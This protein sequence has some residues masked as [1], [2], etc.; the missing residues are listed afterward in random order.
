MGAVE[1][2]L[3]EPLAGQALLTDALA[4][5]AGSSMAEDS[6]TAARAELRR[7]RIEFSLASN[8]RERRRALWP[9]L[10]LVESSVYLLYL[11]RGSPARARAGGT[12]SKMVSSLMK[13]H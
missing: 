12:G 10:C 8:Y 9:P 1:L 7:D 11:R 4:A 2:A 13:K 5:P 3:M 6:A